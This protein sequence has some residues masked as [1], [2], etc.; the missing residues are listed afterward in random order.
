MFLFII[1]YKEG[2]LHFSVQFLAMSVSALISR[3]TVSDTSVAVYFH[4]LLIYQRPA[5]Y[6][7]SEI[8]AC[9]SGL[10][11]PWPAVKTLF[12]ATAHTTMWDL[13]ADSRSDGVLYFPNP[14]AVMWSL[15]E[16]SL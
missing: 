7:Q 3:L 11:H 12:T 6:V 1:P 10:I 14:A 15:A 8:L 16:W 2:F 9:Q 5:F 13:E 4:S